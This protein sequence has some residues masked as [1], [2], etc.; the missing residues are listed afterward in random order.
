MFIN[1]LHFSVIDLSI[2][3]CVNAIILTCLLGAFRNYLQKRFYILFLDKYPNNIEETF[4]NWSLNGFILNLLF[5]G[6]K[7]FE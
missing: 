3:I 7:S 2:C 4:N 5:A 1:F 6:M